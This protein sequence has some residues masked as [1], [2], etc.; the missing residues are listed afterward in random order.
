MN[1]LLGLAM[2][3]KTLRIL[4]ELQ[5]WKCFYC[6][7]DIFLTGRHRDA[8]AAATTDH[9]VPMA[10]GGDNRRSNLVASCRECNNNKGDMS[11]DEYRE[12][13]PGILEKREA[14]RRLRYERRLARKNERKLEGHSAGKTRRLAKVG[15]DAAGAATYSL[16]DILGPALERQAAPGGKNPER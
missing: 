9:R 12:I 15:Y 6:T 8:N 13:L 7:R 16:G 10:A 14:T 1:M 3:S 2:A 4:C 5:G 11:V